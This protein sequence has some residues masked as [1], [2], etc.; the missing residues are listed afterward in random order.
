MVLPPS[1]HKTQMNTPL[2]VQHKANIAPAASHW[3]NSESWRGR[4][5]QGGYIPVASPKDPALPCFMLKPLAPIWKPSRNP[6]PSFIFEAT[7]KPFPFRNPLFMLHFE[8]FGAL[9]KL[10]PPQTPA[11][12]A[13][14][15][16]VF[17]FEA[18]PKP[19]P[20]ESFGFLTIQNLFPAFI[21]YQHTE[22]F[23]L[24]QPLAQTS[25][26]RLWSLSNPSQPMPTFHIEIVGS[27]LKPFLSQTLA[28][29]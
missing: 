9:P 15:L 20:G 25:F 1:E 29:V 13:C 12:V 21:L 16:S 2:L 22:T 10:F 3:S 19:A 7:P 14:W 27:S 18:F 5:R 4:S 17:H 26:W 6:C 11:H 28:H 23:S 24:P 8:S